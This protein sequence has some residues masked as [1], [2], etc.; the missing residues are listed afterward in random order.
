MVDIPAPSGRTPLELAAG[1][2]AAGADV[3]RTLLQHGACVD[4]NAGGVAL[5]AALA[6]SNRERGFEKAE[7]LLRAG[8]S[9]DRCALCLFLWF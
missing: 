8:V 4:G 9:L 5:L 6:A 3:L 2:G 1:N 7:A